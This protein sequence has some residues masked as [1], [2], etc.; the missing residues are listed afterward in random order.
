M[1]AQEIEVRVLAQDWI[2]LSR[3][4]LCLNADCEAISRLSA[5]ACP[6]CGGTAR[7]ALATWIESLAWT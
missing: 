5:P 1:I 6:A 4:A 3:A 2:E 7:V